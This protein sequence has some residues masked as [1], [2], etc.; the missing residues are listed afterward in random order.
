MH[1]TSPNVG[2][3]F[4]ENGALGKSTLNKYFYCGLN[5]DS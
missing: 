5:G 2:I 1:E 4:L 3:S